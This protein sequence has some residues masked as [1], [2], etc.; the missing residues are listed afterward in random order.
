MMKTVEIRELKKHLRSHLR[1]VRSGET[2][3]LTDRGEV[4]AELRP[5]G[6]ATK[7]PLLNDLAQKGTVRLGGPNNP[8]LYPS[9]EGALTRAEIKQLLDEERGDH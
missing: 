3:L 1:L 5:P 6:G 7:Y 8:A 2:I 9:M 4:V